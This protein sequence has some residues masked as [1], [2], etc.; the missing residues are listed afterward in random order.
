MAIT[1]DYDKAY[2]EAKRLAAAAKECESA[3]AESKRVLS[4]LP[5]CWEGAAAGAFIASGEAWNKE[6]QSVRDELLSVSKTIIAVTDAIREA[7][8]RAAEAAR[9][10]GGAGGR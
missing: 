2:G 3:I 7:D 6:M 5:S 9:N 4:A 1:I 8:R 10:S